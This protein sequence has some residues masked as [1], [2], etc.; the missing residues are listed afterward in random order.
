[1]NDTSPTVLVFDV[2]E[3]LLDIT[4]LEPLFERLFGDARVMRQWFAEL[5][6]YSEA[7][8]LAGAYAPFG[9]V[10]AGVLRMVGDVRGVAIAE[11]DTR[12][13]AERVGSMPACADAADALARLGDAGFRLVTLTNSPP[14]NG[15][16]PL[17]RAGLERFFERTFSVDSVGRYKPAPETYA[18]VTD[19]LGVG[20]ES[21]CLVAAHAWDTLGA[22]LAGARAAL[23]TRPGN[24]V[25][26]VPNV[27][28]PDIVGTDLGMVADA[29]IERWSP[30]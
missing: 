4:T 13:L 24:A 27:P 19:S 5:I 8:T 10:G 30:R 1:M 20:I 11:R 2:N 9:A 15:S 6:L 22:Q 12:E 18:A 14:P 17:E 29:I 16:S 26:E 25:I 23:V 7:M 28:R 3:T 21:T